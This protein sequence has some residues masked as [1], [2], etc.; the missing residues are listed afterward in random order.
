VENDTDLQ[1]NGPI[2]TY[3]LDESLKKDESIHSK[4]TE[5]E[6][7]ELWSE[8]LGIEE[9]DDNDDFFDLG[10]DS[11]IAAQLS[12]AIKK[13]FD[14]KISISEFLENCSFNNFSK[15]VVKP[16]EGQITPAFEQTACLAEDSINLEA[17]GLSS[18]ISR[19]SVSGC[20]NNFRRI[21]WP[22]IFPVRLNLP[23]ILT[24]KPLKKHL[25]R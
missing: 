16:D 10:G 8:I 23:V 17:A 14:V 19:R 1:F 22:T 7:R 25:K 6:L 4:V 2:Q 3:K 12:S 9:F 21:K 20:W 13:K 5:E 11:L 15:M 18:F 24:F